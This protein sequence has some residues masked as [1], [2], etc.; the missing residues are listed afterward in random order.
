MG[1]SS[2]GEMDAEVSVLSCS[3]TVHRMGTAL[4]PLGAPS[5]VAGT[6][7]TS[8]WAACVSLQTSIASPLVGSGQNAGAGAVAGA[9]AAAA[10]ASRAATACTI[11]ATDCTWAMVATVCSATGNGGAKCGPHRV[12]PWGA[13]GVGTGST[14]AVDSAMMVLTVCATISSGWSG[15]YGN[16][17]SSS[18]CCMALVASA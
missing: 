4:W 14:T 6:M 16:T 10:L 13:R 3:G 8:C 15:W 5:C 17:P 18:T 7:G 1:T 11:G 12:L 9:A 2:A